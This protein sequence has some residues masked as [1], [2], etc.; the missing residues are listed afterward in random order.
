MRVPAILMVFALAACGTR[1][2]SVAVAPSP[3]PASAPSRTSVAGP[4]LLPD[5]GCSGPV[6]T[7]AATIAPGINECEIVRLKGAPP[8]DVLV[9]ESGRGAREVQVLYAEPTGRELYLFVDGR[10]DR[11]V[12]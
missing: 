1:G 7:T 3:A 4:M 11:I 2:E 10:L 9:G 8:T 6:P 12:K 5:G